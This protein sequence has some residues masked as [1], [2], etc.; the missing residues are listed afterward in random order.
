[1]RILP[2]S[3]AVPSSTVLIVPRLPF[4]YLL[5]V[6]TM[7][8]ASGCNGFGLLQVLDGAAGELYRSVTEGWVF[9]A[10]VA[11]WAPGLARGSSYDMPAYNGAGVAQV[12]TPPYG[13]AVASTISC[14]GGLPP[15]FWIMP[16]MELRLA[17]LV[18][19]GVFSM[20]HARLVIGVP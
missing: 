18:S 5:K 15:D 14:Q 6:A 9:S 19:G 13:V 4:P 17:G 12:A 8:V 16:S 11:T 2:W 20:T 10:T 1:M 3:L 7:G